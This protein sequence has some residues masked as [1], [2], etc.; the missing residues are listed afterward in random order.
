MTTYQKIKK[1][2]FEIIER[3]S[4]MS[5]FLFIAHLHKNEIGKKTFTRLIA[6]IFYY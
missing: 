3:S 1:R 5:I 2:T 4:F 6:S